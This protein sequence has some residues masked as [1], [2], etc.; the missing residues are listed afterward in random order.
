MALLEEAGLS[1]CVDALGRAPR[2]STTAG[3]QRVQMA[4]A[5]IHPLCPPLL[6]PIQ[7]PAHLEEVRAGSPAPPDMLVMSQRGRGPVAAAAY[8][9]PVQATMPPLTPPSCVSCV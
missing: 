1:N 4:A 7:Y 6:H 5:P 2:H 8:F 3:R 9:E